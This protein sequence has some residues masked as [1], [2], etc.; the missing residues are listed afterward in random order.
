MSLAPWEVKA[1]NIQ[2]IQEDDA[3][4]KELQFAHAIEG[5]SWSVPGIEPEVCLWIKGVY[6][7][8]IEIW[9]GFKDTQ[10]A[11]FDICL[12]ECRS[13][14]KKKL[15]T[16]PAQG[17]A[18][19]RRPKS[20]AVLQAPSSSRRLPSTGDAKDG[21]GTA[22]SFDV[23]SNDSSALPEAASFAYPSSQYIPGLKRA[24][25]A[26]TNA[27]HYPSGP[28]PVAQSWNVAK[29][30]GAQLH[31]ALLSD[32]EADEDYEAHGI[33]SAGLPS[34]AHQSERTLVAP[35]SCL[36][37][38]AF[39]HMIDLVVA[40]SVITTAIIYFV[41]LLWEGYKSNV[42]LGI[43]PTG[44]W[45]G[46]EDFFVHS[47]Q[48]FNIFFL[49]ELALRVLVSGRRFYRSLF[50][51]FDTMVVLI[52]ATESIV[53]RA[54]LDLSTEDVTF[55]RLL[56]FMRL[57]RTVRIVRVLNM[58]PPLR[59][60]LKT[61][62]SSVFSLVWCMLVLGILQLICA[63]VMCQTLTSYIQDDMND[64]DMRLW[65]NRHYGSASKAFWTMFE[66]TFSGGWP[67]YAR[68]VIE[69]VSAVYA[70]FFGVYVTFVIFAIIRIVNALFLQETLKVASADLEMQVQMSMSEKQAY[71]DKLRT[72]FLELDKSGD[73]YITLEEFQSVFTD[74]H[75]KAIMGLLGLEIHEVSGL[76]D[77]L[78]DGDGRITYEEFVNGIIILKGQARSQDVI[79]ILHDS[80]KILRLCTDLHLSIAGLHAEQQ[81]SV[82]P[83]PANGHATENGRRLSAPSN[84]DLSSNMSNYSV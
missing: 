36:Q 40:F 24:A 73:G 2:A 81:V 75:V 84:G 52:S 38:K 48:A 39:L 29:R 62:T 19:L 82:L 76:Y 17:D 4:Q 54:I 77:L 63:M 45:E 8:Q 78:D 41:Q 7:K 23:H 65:V 42:A 5:E 16:L 49:L 60:L 25:T 30:G 66:I 68:P 80:R 20:T 31:K 26:G 57:A 35:I 71:I 59:V 56:R 13:E 47:E 74:P 32:K 69:Q 64:M 79:A 18:A 28:S 11:A 27:S 53:L 6:E 37:N 10:T 1:Y 50:N 3:I 72:V 51:W 14:L 12:Q 67:N 61:I 83:T 22:R 21:Y 9:K 34:Q 55:M 43:S 15:T 46:A 58:F 33:E 44:Q 70:A